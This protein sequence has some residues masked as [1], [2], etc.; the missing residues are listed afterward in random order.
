MIPSNMTSEISTFGFIGDSDSEL[1]DL[2]LEL[3]DVGVL[4][5]REALGRRMS[6]SV[7]LTVSS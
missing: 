3:A 4:I 2:A 1:P 7:G 6:G 5:P